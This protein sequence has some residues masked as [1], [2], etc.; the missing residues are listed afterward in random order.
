MSFLFYLFKFSLVY[1]SFFLVVVVDCWVD[2]GG[3]FFSFLL[4]VL[5][6]GFAGNVYLIRN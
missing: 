5:V 2:V 3:I 1:S 4:D 6:Y